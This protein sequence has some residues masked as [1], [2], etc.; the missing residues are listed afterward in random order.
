VTEEAVF[1]SN[2]RI[3]LKDQPAQKLP[4]GKD[5][6]AYR[7]R[8]ALL[9]ASCAAPPY[10]FASHLKERV[11]MKTVAFGEPKFNP[12]ISAVLV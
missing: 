3:R 6:L 4:P 9:N 1:S 12:L 2:C 5:I 7:E 8:E 11:L 10:V